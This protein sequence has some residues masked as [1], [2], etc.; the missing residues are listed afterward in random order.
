MLSSGCTLLVPQIR[1]NFYPY[2]MSVSRLAKVRKELAN[3]RWQP[4]PLKTINVS[5]RNLTLTLV[6]QLITFLSFVLENNLIC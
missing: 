3:P 1:Y 4:E 6:R 5:T 2:T